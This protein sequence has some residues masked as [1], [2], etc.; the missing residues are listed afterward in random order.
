MPQFSHT[1][2]LTSEP[3]VCALIAS[4]L[5]PLATAD[6]DSAAIVSACAAGTGPAAGMVDTASLGTIVTVCVCPFDCPSLL[7]LDP[8]AITL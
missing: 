6:R 7:W 5:L 1:M 8:E 3:G 2:A 4:L